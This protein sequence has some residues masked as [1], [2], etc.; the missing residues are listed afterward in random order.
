[1]EVRPTYR[2]MQMPALKSYFV[3]GARIAQQKLQEI[4]TIKSD[5]QLPR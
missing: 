2:I 5:L 1:M 3:Q 4:V